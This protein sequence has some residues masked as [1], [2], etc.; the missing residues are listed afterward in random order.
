MS[1]AIITL[2]GLVRHTAQKPLSSEEPSRTITIPKQKEDMARY[3]YSDALG[4]KFPPLKQDV[5]I[6]MLPLILENFD[7]YEKVC[8][9]T[10][11]ALKVQQ[12]LLE[13]HH[14]DFDIEKNGLFVSENSNDDKAQFGYI[15]N[16]INQTMDAY[17]R[18]IIDLT[19]GFRHVPIL[20]MID[21][22]MQHIQ[23]PHKIEA[24][25]FG[26]EI[27]PQKEYEIIDLVEY[28]ELA[29]LSYMLSTFEQNYTVSSRFV[30]KNKRYNHI[31]KQ[32]GLFSYHILSNSLKPLI[33]GELIEKLA[34][35]LSALATETEIEHFNTYITDIIEHLLE[36]RSL[37]EHEEWQR[38]HALSRIMAHR[39]YLLNAITLLSEAVGLYCLSAIETFSDDIHEHIEIFRGYIAEG[40]EPAHRYSFYALTSQSKNIVKHRKDF[41]G[42]YLFKTKD[43]D[44]KRSIIERLDALGVEAFQTFI[45]EMDNF[46]NNMAHGNSSDVVLDVKERYHTMLAS[47][48]RFCIEEDILNPKTKK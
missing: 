12:A 9:Y 47:F 37:K 16:T 41:K 42:S 22:I 26:K 6:N 33:E 19:H 27:T 5:Y 36:I 45:I 13:H 32:L 14:I 40:R 29:T 34:D 38:F 10:Q 44:P 48:E 31:A 20:A 18:V 39:G 46:R 4:K 1:K 43:F 23:N 8:V 21:L 3:Y 2:L 11:T 35:E 30:F 28:L 25:L 7:G 24:I 17:E 15:L